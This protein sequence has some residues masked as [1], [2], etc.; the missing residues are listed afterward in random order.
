MSETSKALPAG[1]SASKI[2][3]LHHSL[4]PILDGWSDLC[5][6]DMSDQEALARVQRSQCLWGIL[7]GSAGLLDELHG[8]SY[9]QEAHRC[10]CQSEALELDGRQFLR[11]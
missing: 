4:I 8:G 7:Q 5:D 1:V 11:A 3:S 9:K 10:S 6:W 2:T